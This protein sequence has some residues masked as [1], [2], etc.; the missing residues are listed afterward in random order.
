[1]RHILLAGIL[2]LLTAPLFANNI[3][4]VK[5]D[6]TGTG[7]SW[8]DATGDLT[9][10]LFAAQPEDEVW[11]AAGNYFPTKG[12]NRKKSIIVPAGVKLY[13]GFAGFE[14]SPQQRD[15]QNNISVL[16]GNIGSIADSKDNS[17]S[18][19]YLKDADENTL[20]DGFVIADGTA[21][22]TGPTADRGRC[23]AGLYVDGSGPQGNAAP[24]IQNCIFQ[25]NYARDG[26]AVY[27][28]GRSGICNATFRNCQFLSNKAD[29]DGG[30]V[31]ND[32]RHGGTANPS[33]LSCS[34]SNNMGNYGGAIC[35]YGGK[36]ESSPK[37]Q[38][39]VFR[40]NEAYLRGG[41]IFNMDVDG[42]TKPVINGCQFVDNKAVSGRG[43]Y[44]FSRP[45]DAR[46][47]TTTAT[48]LKMN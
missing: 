26:G 33:F 37:L 19:I 13:G 2:G 32:G 10:A 6:G 44:T 30:A 18:V 39:C 28:N 46:E 48:K 16:S 1:M 43:M 4:F 38:N 9:A 8:T 34:F 21:D 24:V 36:G 45:K 47:G 29:L 17:F 14:T 25:N 40:N 35:N 15:I 12:K 3:I 41:A 20:I 23:G 5:Q 42:V 31:F 22:G 11:V 27:L 7:D